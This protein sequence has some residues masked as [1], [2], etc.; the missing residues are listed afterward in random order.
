MAGYGGVY[1]SIQD[2]DIRVYF[3]NPG[4][5]LPVRTRDGMACGL[6]WGRRRE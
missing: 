3:L 2:R 5:Q 6:A 4:A 1:Y